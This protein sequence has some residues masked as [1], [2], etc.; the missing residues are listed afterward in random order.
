M[1]DGSLWLDMTYFNRPGPD[2][3]VAE[4]SRS[5]WRTPR[6]KGLITDKRWIW[7]PGRPC[8][9]VM[10]K[11]AR[12]LHDRTGER[13][14]VMAGGVA[15]NCVANGRLLRKDLSDI[16]ISPRPATQAARSALALLAW[17]HEM[18][19]PDRFAQDAQRARCSAQHSTTTTS[20]VLSAFRRPITA[21]TMSRP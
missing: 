4:I 12:H 7:L 10:L 17:H 13:R 14:L 19:R 11:I 21:S 9:D 2:D 16:W 8:E 1:E 5:V 6:L 15:L 18:D 20:V 3:D